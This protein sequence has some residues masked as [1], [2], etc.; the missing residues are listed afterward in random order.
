MST[1]SYF[2]EY[3]QI[4]HLFLENSKKLETWNKIGTNDKTDN[5]SLLFSCQKLSIDSRGLDI[6]NL[7]VNNN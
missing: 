5:D 2:S 1:Y 3:M 6:Q 7:P 4:H